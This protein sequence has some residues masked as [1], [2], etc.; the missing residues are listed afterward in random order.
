MAKTVTMVGG[1]AVVVSDGVSTWT[2]SNSAEAA[3]QSEEFASELAKAAP[4]VRAAIAESAAV[5]EE[6]ARA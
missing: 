1:G 2:F 4:E 5:L 6:V 3:K